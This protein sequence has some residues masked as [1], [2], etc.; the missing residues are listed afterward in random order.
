MEAPAAA[1]G[2]P[3]WSGSQSVRFALRI[4]RH[5]PVEHS[6]WIRR[7]VR[8]APASRRRP[9]GSTVGGW[10]VSEPVRDRDS[11]RLR[12]LGGHVPVLRP[13]R[14][15]APRGGRAAVLVLELDALP[16]ADAGVRRD[17]RRQPVPGDRQLAEPRLRGPAGDGHRLALHQR[18]HL[19]LRQP[20]SRPGEDRRARGVL[21]GARRLLLRELGR[22]LRQVAREDG[23]ADRGA[24]RA[25]RFRSSGS[26]SPTRSRSRT[27]RR[28]TAP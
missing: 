18:L 28:A 4:G 22:A 27:T 1:W 26:T 16:G 2:L 17:L 24:R 7:V 9:H 5:R 21:P 15:G 25:R 19:H 23:R 12:G 8:A 14:R 13:L 3:C 11:A 20:G 10:V 6:H